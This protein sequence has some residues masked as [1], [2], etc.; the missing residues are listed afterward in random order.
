MQAPKRRQAPTTRRFSGRSKAIA[1]GLAVVL[2][3]GV[4]I[5]VAATR[6]GSGSS[7]VAKNLAAAGCT[8]KAYPDLGREHVSSL[9]AKVHY[10][11]FPPTSGRHYLQPALWGFYD[12]PVASQ[13]Q[14]VHNLEH[15]GVVVQWGSGVPAL[16]VAQLRSLWQDSPNGMLMAPLP[17]LG[18]KI[19][20]TAWTHLAICPRFDESAVKAFRDAYRAKGPE[21]FPLSVLTP[22]A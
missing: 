19:A 3:A 2:A 8:F 21:R 22:G 11:S 4:A 16:A 14:A 17:K 6:G 15:G 5:A 13:V 7:D 9:T 12:D 18:D 1:A 10:N 20:L